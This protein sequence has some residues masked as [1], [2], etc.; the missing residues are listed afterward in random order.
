MKRN[1]KKKNNNKRIPV[2]SL[3][4]NK[5]IPPELAKIYSPNDKS[6]SFKISFDFYD[7]KICE[8]DNLNKSLT[9]KCLI[10]LKQIGKYNYQNFV[11]KLKPT[12]VK[13]SGHY[14]I[15]YKNVTPDVEISELY[16]GKSSRMFYFIKKHLSYNFFH[17]ISIKNKHLEKKINNFLHKK[18]SEKCQKN[19]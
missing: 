16:L 13:N 17:I 2:S 7:E 4:K 9:K 10:T 1:K 8:I 18:M 19:Q 14:K 6:N 11:E 3:Q 12:S 15:F 5:R